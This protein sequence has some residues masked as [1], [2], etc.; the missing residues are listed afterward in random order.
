MQSRDILKHLSCAVLAAVLAGATAGCNE[1]TG[2]FGGSFPVVVIETSAGTIQVELWPDKAPISV[3]NFLQYVDEGFYDNTIFHRCIRGF[4]I[5]GGGLTPA[6]KKKAT[7]PPI[8]NEASNGLK[9]VRGTIAMALT[10]G[11]PDSATSQFFINTADNDNLDRGVDPFGYAV[12]GQV[13]DGMGVVDVIGNAPV[14][15]DPRDG[16]PANPIVIKSIHRL[17]RPAKTVAPKAK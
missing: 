7:H 15:G 5:Q 8:H 11:H 2:G 1:R 12:F 13:T 3:E 14:V 17:G 16:R 9:N 4:M 10:P 6:W